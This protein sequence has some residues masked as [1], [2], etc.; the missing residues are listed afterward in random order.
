MT[1]SQTVGEPTL[2]G[3]AA[4]AERR[5]M[6]QAPAWGKVR[7][8]LVVYTGKGGRAGAEEEPSRSWRDFRVSLCTTAGAWC[9]RSSWGKLVWPL[10]IS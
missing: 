1:S 7:E 3:Y 6:A 10:H 8:S 9:G 2:K 4:K 5:E